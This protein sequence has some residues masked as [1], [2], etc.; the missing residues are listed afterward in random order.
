MVLDVDHFVTLVLEGANRYD[1]D[2]DADATRRIRVRVG[3]AL[4]QF[5]GSGARVENDLGE[6]LEQRFRAFGEALAREA[7]RELPSYRTRPTGQRRLT[8]PD[9]L[10]LLDGLCPGFWPI[11]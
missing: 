10:S 3:R 9:V 5:G 7:I 11:C 4:D 6:R 2:L 8:E 1:F